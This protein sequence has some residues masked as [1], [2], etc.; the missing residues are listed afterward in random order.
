MRMGGKK[1]ALAVAV[2][3]AAAAAAAAA[4]AVAGGTVGVVG[5]HASDRIEVGMAAAAAAAAA[6]TK[7]TL[8]GGSRLL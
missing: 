3:S 5:S 1:W 8:V 7:P 2:A 6:P 4:L